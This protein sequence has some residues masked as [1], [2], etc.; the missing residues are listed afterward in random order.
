MKIKKV[1]CASGMTGFYM[2]DKEA[3]REG[4]K[5]D[6]FIYRGKPMTKGFDTVRQPGE[7]VSVIFVMEN[8]EIIFG[9]C[10]V[11]QYAASGGR[12]V[13]MRAKDLV[14]VIERDVTPWLTGRDITCFRKDATEF[15]QLKVNGERLP[16]S[17][18][19]G[20][21][22]AI[23]E[24]VAR[25]RRL[26]MAEVILN[27]YNLKL[28]LT[29]VRINAQSGDERY[30]NVDK[31]ILKRVGMMPH[32]LIN[33]VEKKFG[34]KGEI[35]SE[36]ITWVRN[37][38]LDIGGKDY[39]PV[40]RYDVYGIIG[41]A[42]QDNL[43]AVGEYL[44]KVEEISKP[45]EVFVEMP[46]DLK[47]NEK[48][49]EG[50]K[51]LRKYLDQA[52][53]KLKLIID[54]YANT[55]EEIKEWVDAKGAD[56]VQVKTID[57]GGI[58]NIVEAVLYCKQHGVLAYQGGTCNETDKSAVVCVNLA[59]ATQP[60]AMAGKPGM[61]VDEGVMI[62]NNEQERLLAILRDKYPVQC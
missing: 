10:A 20:V 8:D 45:F 51:Y 4:A 55:F 40:L 5:E 14:T 29:P 17:I 32:G 58:N 21:T 30:T 26:T 54:E 56:M 33:N 47:S 31:M 34:K 59:V 52:G 46:I 25:E 50:M 23:L 16:T 57:L 37:R 3:I 22:Q 6:G 60:F 48:Q 38:I 7:A 12:E 15:D 43:D 28:Q 42:F 19:Y 35:F 39:K 49:L 11:A 1:L 27:E 53:S 18:R 36:W 2:D 44:L 41:K 13:P 9:D 61:G 24:A 62:V